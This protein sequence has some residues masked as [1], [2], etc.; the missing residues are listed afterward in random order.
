[1]RLAS[2]RY[3]EIKNCIADMLEDYGVTAFSC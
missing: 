1:M 3:E 2:S